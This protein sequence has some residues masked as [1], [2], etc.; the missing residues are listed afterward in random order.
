MGRLRED[1]LERVEA[2]AHRVA[3]VADAIERAGRSRRVV[4]QMYGCGTSVGA[5]TFE[6]A[7]AMSR[8]DFARGVSIVL[9]ELSEVRFWLRF[10]GKRGWIKPGLLEPLESE[11]NELRLI[12][13]AILSRTKR[14]A[15]KATA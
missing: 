4:E 7:E 11:A 5:N 10:V 6:A 13:G 15:R 1:L 2:F 8:A 3:D 12:F 14:A 9:K